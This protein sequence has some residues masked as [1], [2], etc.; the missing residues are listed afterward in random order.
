MKR[1]PGNLTVTFQ[2]RNYCQE[3]TKMTDQKNTILKLNNN[4]IK[5]KVRLIQK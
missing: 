1:A 2:L 4:K 3:I 5:R